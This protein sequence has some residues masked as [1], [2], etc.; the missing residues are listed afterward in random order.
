MHAWP[1][2]TIHECDSVRLKDES[3]E[4]FV[5]IAIHE[6]KA[7]IQEQATGRDEIVFLKDCRRLSTYH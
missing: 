2:E 7:W 6:E 1:S 5:V 4:R 3:D